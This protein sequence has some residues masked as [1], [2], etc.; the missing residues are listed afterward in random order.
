MKN[1]CLKYLFFLSVLLLPLSAGAMDFSL[2]LSQNAGIGNQT[3]EDGGFDYQ[4]GIL[5][6]FSFLLGES[7]D[8]FISAG[9]TLGV[10]EEDFYY[11][12]ELLR[13]EVS[14]RFGN[15]RIRA[16]RMQYAAPL[17]LVASGLFDG[18]QFSYNSSGGT[19]SA[20][21]WYTG[22]LYKKNANIIMTGEDK[23]LYEEPV[24]YDDF[25]GTYFAPGRFL[26]SLDWEHPSIAELVNLKA[27]I[28]AQID[29]SG[30]DMQYHSQYLTLK[31]A[32]PVKKFLFEI[33]GSFETAQ[34]EYP[35]AADK[36]PF[37]IAFAWDLGIFWTLPSSFNSRLSLTGQFA[38]G[39][40]DGLVGAFVPIT[41]KFYGD[42]LKA[43][44][45]GL[46]VF[47]LNYT[48][49]LV[50]SFG[51]SL[52]DSLFVRNDLGTYADYPAAAGSDGYFLGNELFAR[53]IWSPVSDLQFN[54]GGGVF[55]PG[56]DE[57]SRWRVE[58]SAI[59]AVY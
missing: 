38:G 58:L 39:E 40:T 22:L 8:L 37:N 19:F 36:E 3:N 24:I 26:A 59:L 41:T 11:I 28:T 51:L 31:A 10:E 46:S 5:P 16:G 45:S 54:L 15:G 57:K 6:G 34:L 33:G 53:F 35:A 14:Y 47:A 48:A 21:V 17:P 50:P 52:T 25:S 9:M 4:L 49:R 55:I 18:A 23:A 7:G 44:I 32:I 13:T 2:V 43:G 1:V 30:G 56:P 20:G 42:V 12:P 29:L 27:A